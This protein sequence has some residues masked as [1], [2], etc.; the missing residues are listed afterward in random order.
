MLTRK[1]VQ[2]KKGKR[3]KSEREIRRR[4]FRKEGKRG[5]EVESKILLRTR[6]AAT[7]A[8]RD[9]SAGDYARG[10]STRTRAADQSV[11]EIYGTDDGREN[12]MLSP[13]ARI[14]PSS[15]PR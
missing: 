4:D 13:A 7:N 5:K 10:I 8:S 12:V 11:R 3:R 14:V 15:A 6:A 2:K 9:A 1:L